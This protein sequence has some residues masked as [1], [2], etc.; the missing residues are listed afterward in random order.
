MSVDRKLGIWMCA[1]LVV[2]NMIGAGIFLLPASLAPFGL[3]SVIAWVATSAGAILL[4]CVFA[5]LARALPEAA[6]PYE[7]VRLAFGDMAAF[8]VAWGF[9]VSIWVGNAA[10]VTGTVSYL[11]AIFPALRDNVALNALIS[12]G[13]VW[14]MTAVNIRGVRSA[15]AVQVVTTVLKLLPLFA[16]CLLGIFLFATHDA[17]LGLH[18]ADAAP[19]SAGGITAAASLTLWALLGFESASVAAKRVKDPERTIPR[20]TIIGCVAV[21][22]IYILSCTT[23]ILL[24][25]SAEL[26]KSGAPFADLATR[27][28]GSGAGE[29]VAIFAAISG[30]GCLNG[31]IL[32]HGEVPMQMA[33]NHVLPSVFAKLSRWQ[34]PAI[35][36]CVSSTLVSA[37]VLMNYGKSLVEMFTFLIL[38]STTATLVL[39]LSTALAALWLLHRRRITVQGPNAALLAVAAVLG[40]LYALWTFYGA[41]KEALFWGLVLM[42]ASVPVYFLMK[43][44]AA[45]EATA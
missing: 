28:W 39:Y 7:Y 35:G 1:A 6:G 27:F 14:L 21:A 8:V 32:L 45:V 44:G 20:A 16:I 42:V 4:A 31:W 38:L 2:G 17:R 33:R 3:N 30:F 12:L 29:A 10:L 34:T 9:W 18:A 41:G 37:L 26:A 24:T 23:V 36:L 11:G 13:A 15:G 40:S 19:I 25:P 22:I 43:R 5:A